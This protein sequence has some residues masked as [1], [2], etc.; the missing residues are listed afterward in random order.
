[1]RVAGPNDINEILEL[2]YESGKDLGRE[3]LDKALLE[4][5]CYVVIDKNNIVGAIIYSDNLE[6][7]NIHQLFIQ[8][9]NK[10]EVIEKLFYAIDANDPLTILINVDEE[11]LDMQI[12]LRDF[13]KMKCTDIIK[14][15]DKNYYHFQKVIKQNQFSGLVLKDER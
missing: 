14:G 7:I 6:E 4:Y 8:H 5:C 1:M 3:F 9:E 11:D 10:K 15:L 2:A 13:A 12:A